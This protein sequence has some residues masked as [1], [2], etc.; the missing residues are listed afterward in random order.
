MRSSVHLAWRSELRSIPLKKTA[1]TT[2]GYLEEVEM[3]MLLRQPD[4]RMLWVCGMTPC[5]S[6]FTTAAHGQIRRRK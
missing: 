6:S 4:R 2:L 3:D 1:K 5:C